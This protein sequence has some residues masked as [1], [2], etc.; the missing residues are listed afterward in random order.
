MKFIDLRFTHYAN[1]A[2]DNVKV[3][4]T[5]KKLEM[6]NGEPRNTKISFY[7]YNRA[8]SA[9]DWKALALSVHGLYLII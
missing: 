3:T 7:A 5:W 4:L 1:M 8:E 9:N 2:L 6:R